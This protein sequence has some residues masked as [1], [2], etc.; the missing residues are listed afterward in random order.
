MTASTKTTN[1]PL[2]IASIMASM[3]MV[4]IEATI[5][6]TVMPQIA[7]ELGGLHLYS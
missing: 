7:S 5:V 6:S 2:V 3:A 4:A 1:R